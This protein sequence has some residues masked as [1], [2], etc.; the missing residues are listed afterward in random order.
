MTQ[1]WQVDTYRLATE[2]SYLEDTLKFKGYK[3]QLADIIGDTVYFR[4]YDEP[5]VEYIEFCF[6]RLNRGKARL[7]YVSYVEWDE[8]RIG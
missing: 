2:N 3:A 8:S 6:T 4:Y 1:L 7:N 5:E